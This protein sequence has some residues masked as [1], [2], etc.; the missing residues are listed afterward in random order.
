MPNVPQ[1]PSTALRA[2]VA[3]VGS[4]LEATI[5]RTKDPDQDRRLEDY[6]WTALELVM[7]AQASPAPADALVSWFPGKKKQPSYALVSTM[8]A[9]QAHQA[10]VGTL[11][12]ICVLLGE[13]EQLARE[14][15]VALVRHAELNIPDDLAGL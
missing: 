5:T 15:G 8:D 11:A 13:A 2:E 4:Q 14:A 7:E 10:Y 9:D 12:K 6:F 3:A 1:N